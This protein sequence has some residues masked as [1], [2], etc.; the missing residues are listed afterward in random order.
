MSDAPAKSD[1]TFRRVSVSERLPALMRAVI[2]EK[3]DGRR[4]VAARRESITE[5][6]TYHWGLLG[7]NEIIGV[8]SDVAFW[9]ERV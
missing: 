5:K 3:S 6:G 8:V 4:R 2:V 7:E 1:L 9:F